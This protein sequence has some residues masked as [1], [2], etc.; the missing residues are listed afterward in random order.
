MKIFSNKNCKV[1]FGF[2]LY[3]RVL[4]ATVFLAKLEATM[5]DRELPQGFG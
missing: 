3:L 1:N 5:H 2:E 4:L